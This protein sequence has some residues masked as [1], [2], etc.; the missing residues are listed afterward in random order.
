MVAKQVLD[1]VKPVAGL[2]KAGF[3]VFGVAVEGVAGLVQG[4]ESQ[5][6]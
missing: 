6:V 2:A 5:H 3:D 1:L 4:L